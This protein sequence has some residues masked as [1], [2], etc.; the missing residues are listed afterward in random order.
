L[1]EPG[2]ALR[3]LIILLVDDDVVDRMII[4]RALRSGGLRCE[5]L[6]ANDAGRGIEILQSEK[7]DCAFLDFNMPARDGLWLVREARA[8]GIRTPLIVLT[9]QGDERIAVELMKAG[10]TDYFSKTEATPE[11]V[12]SGLRQALRVVGVEDALR[13]SQ[14]RLRLAI[15]AT[16]LGTWD[17][18][19]KTGRFEWSE[20][21]KTL[22]G[23][24][25]DAAIDYAVFLARLH[26][27]DRELVDAAVKRAL[28]P[29]NGGIY[30]VEYR[31][32][33]SSNGGERWLRANGRAF[34]DPEG[35]PTRF[36]GTL[37]DIGERNSAT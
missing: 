31:T 6:E 19:P 33:D 27:N 25:A 13:E 9:G 24:P 36:I 2:D 7:V 14:Q 21:C 32:L 30:D 15:D 34:F 28:D 37:Q 11:R 10:A 17:F 35:R 5:L 1:I 4:R 8:R 22:L 3:E 29:A 12:V 16:E 26:P 23:L 20:R 18:E